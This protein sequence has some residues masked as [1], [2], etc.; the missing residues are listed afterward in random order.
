MIRSVKCFP[1]DVRSCSY[2][3]VR[4][5][6]PSH[7]VGGCQFIFSFQC[8]LFSPFLLSL[9]EKLSLL[10]YIFCQGEC[11]GLKNYGT[12]L[13]IFEQTVVKQAMKLRSQL[14]GTQG[15]LLLEAFIQQC[16]FYSSKISVLSSQMKCVICQLILR[17][18]NSFIQQ[19]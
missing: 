8:L 2:S 13:V 19:F 9:Q 6:I 15:N 5:S 7:L 3:S 14:T 1:Y 11:V 10:L 4:L 18:G 12:S 16:L 17:N